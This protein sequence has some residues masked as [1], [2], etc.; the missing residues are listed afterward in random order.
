MY[1]I[2]Y[3]SPAENQRVNRLAAVDLESVWAFYD[4]A[5]FYA[6]SFA[7]PVWEMAV[8]APGGGR[9]SPRREDGGRLIS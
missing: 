9:I 5:K 2:E 8:T 1:L 7:A 4:A 3:I 6:D